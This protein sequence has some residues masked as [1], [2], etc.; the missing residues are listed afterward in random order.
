MSVHISPNIIVMFPS[1]TFCGF[2]SVW[3]RERR[4]TAL[5][6]RTLMPALSRKLNTT[7]RLSSLCAAILGA[8]LYLLPGEEEKVQLGHRKKKKK[9]EETARDEN[10]GPA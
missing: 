5:A 10:R 8:R 7:L 1:S 3:K 2:A 6:K 4:D 9:N